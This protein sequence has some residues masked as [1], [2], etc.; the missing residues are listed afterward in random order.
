MKELILLELYSKGRFLA[1]VSYNLKPC[2]SF[3]PSCS[4]ISNSWPTQG[5]VIVQGLVLVL[6]LV[7]VLIHGIGLVLVLAPLLV[8][9]PLLVYG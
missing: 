5:R 1:S 3:R 2:T 8:L 4:Y 7:S 9:G 6:S